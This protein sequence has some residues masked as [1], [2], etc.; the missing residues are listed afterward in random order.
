MEEPGR[1]GLDIRED[2]VGGWWQLEAALVAAVPALV[3]SG[4]FSLL[5]TLI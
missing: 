2:W 5:P 1:L 4:A 3:N